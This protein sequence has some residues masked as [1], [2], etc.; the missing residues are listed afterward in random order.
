MDAAIHL[1]DEMSRFTLKVRVTGRRRAAVRVWAGCKIIFLAA[2]IMATVNSASGDRTHPE[3]AQ[4]DFGEDM[5]VCTFD[6]ELNIAAEKV[7]EAVM[8]AVKHITA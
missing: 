8:W 5:A 2:A 7:E 4:S 1:P 6:R 3:P